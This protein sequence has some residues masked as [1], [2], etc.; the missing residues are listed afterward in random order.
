MAKK[1]SALTNIIENG[2][3][4]L[5]SSNVFTDEYKEKL[6]ELPDRVSTLENETSDIISELDTKVDK[7]EG[8]GLSQ[9]N[10]TTEEKLKLANITTPM[11]IVGRVD[12][13][14]DLPT[15]NVK[16]G[17]A[18]LVGLEGSASFEEYVCISVD[19]ITGEPTWERL[20]PATFR[21]KQ[22]DWNENNIT[23]EEHVKNRTHWTEPQEKTFI[24]NIYDIPEWS[25]D[26]YSY[27][28]DF[29]VII[30]EPGHQYT[31]TIDGTDYLLSCTEENN[32]YGEFQDDTIS[33]V[34]QY[35][36]DNEVYFVLETNIES[37][38][39]DSHNLVIED[40]FD[41]SIYI[42]DGGSEEF[43]I[44]KD[45]EFNDGEEYTINI[46]NDS[47]ILTGGHIEEYEYELEFE[48]NGR[49]L[50]V[51]VEAGEVTITTNIRNIVDE[52]LEDSISTCVVTDSNDNV[53]LSFDNTSM[54]G[55][56]GKIL[57]QIEDV[58]FFTTA[59]KEI[60]VTINDDLY[61]LICDEN[62]NLNYVDGE[63][64]FSLIWNHYDNYYELEI[65][66]LKY[67]N[68][69]ITFTVE[70][71]GELVHLLAD[72]FLSPN[73]A[74]RSDIPAN[75]YILNGSGYGSLRSVTSQAE[76]DKFYQIGR[77]SVTFGAYTKAP[78]VYSF[79]QG[80]ESQANGAYSFAQGY[81]TNS[82]GENTHT[83]GADTT[84]S[85]SASHAEGD[86]T[87]ASGK[88]SH[89]E[90]YNTT[91]SGEDSH[92]EG[93][94][95]L[96][97]GRSQKVFGTFNI[98][99]T[100]KRYEN[101]ANHTANT[102]YNVGDKVKYNNGGYICIK[103]HKSTSTGVL[104]N[105]NFYN[106][107]GQ[108]NFIEIVGN[109]YGKN[110]TSNRVF[111][112]ARTLDW[113]GN[114]MIA[115][116]L[117]VNGNSITVGGQQILPQVQSDYNQKNGNA[118]DFVKNKPCYD[119][120]ETIYTDS[121]V[122]S[123]NYEPMYF[124]FSELFTAGDEV[125]VDY[126]L[127]S[128][129]S[130]PG[131]YSEGP[132]VVSS[133][134]IDDPSGTSVTVG[135]I[136]TV[137]CSPLNNYNDHSGKLSGNPYTTHIKIYKHEIKKLDAGLVADSVLNNNGGLTKKISYNGSGPLELDFSYSAI[138]SGDPSGYMF[139][140]AIS[141]I[142]LDCKDCTVGKKYELDLFLKLSG[143]QISG[144]LDY[145]VGRLI[146]LLN[147]PNLTNKMSNLS[148]YTDGS[149]HIKIIY[150]FWSSNESYNNASCEILFYPLE[151]L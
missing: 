50:K 31:V 28:V 66:M 148:T 83:E 108:G 36:Y 80:Y 136:G 23:K 45:I 35:K 132:F 77:G 111:S 95:T 101:W 96:A 52:Y 26:G 75:N 64:Y 99:D 14:D 114:E 59:G 6:D 33:I 24:D 138:T 92:S 67:E 4:K 125:Y 46:D 5:I 122:Q 11:Q 79:T 118:V 145:S 120:G 102:Q 141:E 128:G 85:G 40:L 37:L 124:N 106:I 30:F 131:N 20:G 9:E 142:T 21:Q 27:D 94:Y 90:G 65:S 123:V 60:K 107:T 62:N 18:Y 100:N 38:Y 113:D 140:Y 78:G 84:A 109:G 25:A 2:K 13:V 57:S 147:V 17:D 61:T 55:T 146:T 32:L 135:A 93:E 48:L 110:R 49:I 8:K 91:A 104:N 117:T 58:E 139:S 86:H 3:P 115:G 72:K 137:Y 98:D 22:V 51:S 47:Y 76:E 127:G 88:K 97:S 119:Y 16:K 7:E 151:V 103:A 56:S 12:V 53:V 133:Y 63:D 130:S 129:S 29:Q 82:S 19:T 70:G 121:D 10:Y 74:R 68:S 71:E 44:S 143:K 116:N 41:G 42:Y 105:T 15:E 89:A 34:S 39:D 126:T 87:T 1:Q 43:S 149:Y 54:Y 144:S 112:N 69:P 81:R 150:C 73:I 134:T